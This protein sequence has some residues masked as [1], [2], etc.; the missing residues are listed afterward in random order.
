MRVHLGSAVAVAAEAG[1]EAVT[2]IQSRGF[3]Q[4]GAHCRQMLP[5]NL[6]PR[7]LSPAARAAAGGAQADRVCSAGRALLLRGSVC[8][9]ERASRTAWADQQCAQ[10]GTEKHR[11]MMH[12]YGPLAAP[13]CMHATHTAQQTD[14]RQTQKQD[15]HL[16][17]F[18]HSLAVCAQHL[19]VGHHLCQLRLV[20]I[21]L[22]AQAIELAVRAVI[23]LLDGS[24]ALLAV[25]L[26]DLLVKL[27]Q[28]R[29]QRSAGLRDA[30]RPT[31]FTSTAVVVTSPI[32][33][34]INKEPGLLC[35]CAGRSKQ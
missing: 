2:A 12:G 27:L 21:H 22:H 19:I 28:A 26:H 3:C 31:P 1:A 8:T 18:R 35:L 17:S 23:V 13:F 34:K 25:L 29:E 14:S 10:Q 15:T 33:P 5:A 16:A 11:H 7:G 24:D 30:H 6:W 32:A 4:L 9:S 20:F